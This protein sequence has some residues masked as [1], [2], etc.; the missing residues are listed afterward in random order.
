ML[1][2]ST[3][4]LSLRNKPNIFDYSNENDILAVSSPGSLC[5]FRTSEFGS[6]FQ[7]L[8]SEQLYRSQCIRIQQG[9]EFLVAELVSGDISLWNPNRAARPLIEWHD[10]KQD[11]LTDV[12]WSPFNN[13]I[14][15]TS[16]VVGNLSLRDI[17][18]KMNSVSTLRLGK[19]CEMLR[20]SSNTPFLSVSC[21]G[22]YVLVWDTRMTPG[23]NECYCI[24]EP[25]TQ[26]I[27]YHWSS[28]RPSIYTVGRNQRVEEWTLND[29]TSCYCLNSLKVE[30]INDSSLMI[31][32][33]REDGIILVQNERKPDQNSFIFSQN[34]VSNRP[35]P[36][37][38]ES[39]HDFFSK[40]AC[41]DSKFLGLKWK[42]SSHSSPKLLT[43]TETGLLHML[44]VPDS[45]A[46]SRRSPVREYEERLRG[47]SVDTNKASLKRFSHSKMKNS[48]GS[49]DRLDVLAIPVV[50]KVGTPHRSPLVIGPHTF[51]ALLEED[52]QTLEKGVLNGSL[53]GIRLSRIDQ[54]ARRVMI[55]LLIPTAGTFPNRGANKL[56]SHPLGMFRLSVNN[57][58][59]H[60]KTDDLLQFYKTGVS[61]MSVELGISFPVKFHHFWHP[62]FTVEDKS[63]LEFGEQFFMSV[64]E[65]LAEIVKSFK[66]KPSGLKPSTSTQSLQ[67]TQQHHH[68]QS[69]RRQRSDLS[70]KHPL[71]ESMLC[72][73]AMY[74]RTRVIEEWERI[75][76]SD[77]KKLSVSLNSFKQSSG[78]NVPGIMSFLSDQDCIENI[79]AVFSR[80]IPEKAYSTPCRTSAGIFGPNGSLVFFG[81]AQLTLATPTEGEEEAPVKSAGDKPARF[82]KAYAYVMML[83]SARLNTEAMLSRTPSERGSKSSAGQVR[84]ADS[85]SMLAHVEEN[86]ISSPSHCA[87]DSRSPKSE[88]PLNQGVPM[89]KVQ[90]RER[91]GT[92]SSA[93]EA[94]R[95]RAESPPAVLPG[96]ESVESTDSEKDVVALKEEVLEASADELDM[97][98]GGKSDRT[99]ESDD[100]FF[101][102]TDVSDKDENSPLVLAPEHDQFDQFKEDGG[103]GDQEDS[104]LSDEDSSVSAEPLA[105]STDLL[106]PIEDHSNNS[107]LPPKSSFI[108][109]LSA[110]ANDS[111]QSFFVGD[112]DSTHSAS[113]QCLPESGTAVNSEL[114][115]GL[116]HTAKRVFVVQVLRVAFRAEQKLAKRYFHGPLVETAV[117]VQPIPPTLVRE[118]DSW[119]S[120]VGYSLSLDERSKLGSRVEAC[121]MNALAAQ[122]ILPQEGGLLQFWN[123]LGVSL[124]VLSLTDTT[125]SLL[126]WE[127]SVLGKSLFSRL[128]SYMVSNRDL[129]TCAVAVCVV[130]GSQRVA[131]L[132]FR[133]RQSPY[134]GLSTIS[135]NTGSSQAG[136]HHEEYGKSEA[137]EAERETLVEMLE[138]ALYDYATVLQRWGENVAA[139]Q[140]AKHI[141]CERTQPTPSSKISD[142]SGLYFYVS[143]D[144]SS[145][146][147]TAASSS[148]GN[149]TATGRGKEKR[150]LN[151][152]MQAAKQL[153]SHDAA[154][155]ISSRNSPGEGVWQLQ[156]C[157]VCQMK[158]Q[159]VFSACLS[160]GHGGHA[161]HMK[162]WFSLHQECPSGC[163]CLCVSQDRETLP[164]LSFED[165]IFEQETHSRLELTGLDLPRNHVESAS[166]ATSYEYIDMMS[167]AP[168][169]DFLDTVMIGD[170]EDYS[171]QRVQYDY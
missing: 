142:S 126:N 144:Y 31:P 132:C 129:Q 76:D 114:R 169:S 127:Q 78:D 7:V 95:A 68:N 69:L 12:Q 63:G 133:G 3:L 148:S 161:H 153:D 4:Q 168:P 116:L 159:G 59:S 83:E 151:D 106:S 112:L 43:L 42:I 14:L 137:I 100:Q 125:G 21:E 29:V 150:A 170:I 71:T 60:Y 138:L 156:H 141:D 45:A 136:S 131:D 121:K 139:A 111:Q 119:S 84:K 16:S 115:E 70:V 163:G 99:E 124:S 72:R 47:D 103:S 67:Q 134:G 146:N 26:I 96:P 90:S 75:V 93:S 40:I 28:L 145:S 24:F 92:N 120:Q 23:K 105:Q 56:V 81:G 36:N 97:G 27:D 98:K 109:T 166:N 6:P 89:I 77:T 55:E 94:R 154:P 17:R 8:Y 149:L 61:H 32:K 107:P 20:W 15:A 54:F 10:T 128:V 102:E 1:Q 34:P 110:L 13:N 9:R 101:L 80:G 164:E 44:S 167:A 65:G 22:R 38:N 58:M 171:G 41:S 2:K 87:S 158:V 140:V 51:R 50:E 118:F 152:I 64:M 160:C 108:N 165:E 57:V 157:V 19:S 85:G 122:A 113:K 135:S 82:I 35:I 104:P 37:N 155:V 117:S 11:S 33:H 30:H 147:E 91:S 123:M 86:D 49:T 53:E 74:F 46:V 25:D 48:L 79:P 143:A 66:P 88:S 130:G 162:K 39:N 52:F 73:I 5:L 18:S 62:S